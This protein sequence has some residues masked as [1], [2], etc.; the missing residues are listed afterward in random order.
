MIL[1]YGVKGDSDI[2]QAMSGMYFRMAGGYVTIIPVVPPD[3]AQY[4]AVREF[5][6]LATLPNADEAIRIFLAQKNVRAV[7]LADEGEERWQNLMN[8]RLRYFVREPLSDG[9]KAAVHSMFATLGVEPIRVGRVELYMVPLE[10]LAP[11]RNKPVE[12][13]KTN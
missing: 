5:Y 6:L 9:E 4:L 10:T 1:P 3:Y 7:V 8:G 12:E 11:Y 13:G 2:W